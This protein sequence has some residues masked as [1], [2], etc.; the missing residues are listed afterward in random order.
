MMRDMPFPIRNLINQFHK[1]LRIFTIQKHG[2]FFEYLDHTNTKNRTNVFDLSK[3]ISRIF[4]RRK[5]YVYIYHFVWY[6]PRSFAIVYGNRRENSSV[7]QLYE[8]VNE[9]ILVKSRFIEETRRGLIISRYLKPVF[10]P[11]GNS[12]NII[13]FEQINKQKAFPRVVRILLNEGVCL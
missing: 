7:I 5:S 13:R 1:Y 4:S 6:S 9:R 8:I 12:I 3:Q 10:S 11:G 2:K